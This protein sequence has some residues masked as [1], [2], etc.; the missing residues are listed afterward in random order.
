ME[1]H[2]FEFIVEAETAIS[3]QS[4]SEG[5]HGV[6]MRKKARLADGSIADIP[7]ITGD[8]F[9]HSLR[10]AAAIATLDAAGILAD[11]NLSEGAVRLLFSG[12]MVTGRG[13]AAIIRLE[14]Y[15]RLCDITPSLKLF[16]GCV[17]NGPREGCLRVD[18]LNVLC[19]EMGRYVPGWALDWAK[20]Q[21]IALLESCE[22]VEEQQRV[23]MDSLNRD[24]MQRL[25]SAPA[26]KQLEAR[27]AK[28]EKAHETGDDKEAEEA[29]SSSMPRT[30]E[31]FIMG[32]LFYA[33]VSAYCYSPLDV[34]TLM[35]TLGTFFLDPIIGGKRATGHGRLR[36]LHG[37]QATVL[38]PSENANV[39]D[40]AAPGQRIGQMFRAHVAER[41][42][43]LRAFVSG[44]VNA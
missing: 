31:R 4:G 19:E 1:L 22:Y 37:K 13:D 16:G 36:V 42:E 6:L 40:L 15:R 41:A 12:G 38:R 7:Y 29:K 34:D 27:L 9:R 43:D 24:S 35:A 2:S 26:R 3:H 11:P 14:D 32:T 25:L 21:G 30:F 23:R 18:E 39:L 8:A 10:T 44:E 33:R 20:E 5:N 28:R 17:D